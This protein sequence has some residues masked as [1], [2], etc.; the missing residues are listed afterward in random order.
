MVYVSIIVD[1]Y[2]KMSKMQ[3]SQIEQVKRR[4]ARWTV[5]VTKIVQDLDWRILE[6]RR[7]GAGLQE[8]KM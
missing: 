4:V 5:S 7:A 2:T 3:V 1:T 8:T 6:Q